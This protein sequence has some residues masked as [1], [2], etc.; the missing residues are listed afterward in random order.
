MYPRYIQDIQAKY[1]IPSGSPARPGPNDQSMFAPGRPQKDNLLGI[2]LLGKNAT[3]K[4]NVAVQDDEQRIIACSLLKLGRCISRSLIEDF[5]SQRKNIIP[6]KLKL[7]GKVGWDSTLPQMATF[8]SGDVSAQPIEG[9]AN[10]LVLHTTAF[11]KCP[12]CKKV[13][14]STC[15]AF[16][17]IDL[18]K[19]QKCT[20]C[21]HF[22]AVKLW[23]CSCGKAWHLCQM[24]KHTP[25]PHQ[26]NATMHPLNGQPS[27]PASAS[28]RKRELPPNYLLSYDEMLAEDFRTKQKNEERAHDY[29]NR[30]ILLGNSV[31]RS[32]PSNFLSP[33]L[34]RR[35]LGE[36]GTS[37]NA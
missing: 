19:T 24:H 14:P 28:K 11:F 6:A 13:E 18:D 1:K 10:L 30:V 27:Y 36:L 35:F 31:H 17:H 16:Q 21:K 5:L 12:H 26:H 33:N 2:C 34:K 4:F 3:L 15:A 25:A 7:K 29:E 20:A 23:K 37:T 22:S 32:I 9:A 8:G